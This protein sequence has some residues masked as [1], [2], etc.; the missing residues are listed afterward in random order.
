MIRHMIPLALVLLGL[1]A[2]CASPA[3]TPPELPPEPPP[4]VS[5]VP[6]QSG[7]KVTVYYPTE[8]GSGLAAETRHSTMSGEQLAEVVLREW[9]RGPGGSAPFGESHVLYSKFIA[10][11]LHIIM[12]EATAGT[13]AAD[14]LLLQS[15][16]LS[17][18]RV[19]PGL[20][21]VWIPVAEE[22]LSIVPD[23]SL[24]PDPADGAP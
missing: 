11:S 4:Q 19:T 10:G 18:D 17:L 15:L 6:L 14:P 7:V 16:A 23:H 3:A 24:L 1:L 20:Q 5:P 12:P 2:G 22:M 21:I 13:I 8:D 9:M